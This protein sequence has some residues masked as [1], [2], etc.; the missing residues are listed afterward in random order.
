ML[1]DVANGYSSGTIRGERDTFKGVAGTLRYNHLYG[2]LAE[3]LRSGLQNR[4]HRFKSGRCLHVETN[5]KDFVLKSTSK[6]L[7]S[8]CFSLHIK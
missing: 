1:H 3:W 6:A 2:A 5:Y 7:S 8:R 4:V